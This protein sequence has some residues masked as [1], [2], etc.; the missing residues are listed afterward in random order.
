MKYIFVPC[1]LYKTNNVR[2]RHSIVFKRHF[3][4]SSLQQKENNLSYS[5]LPS[6]IKVFVNLEDNNLVLSYRKELKGKAGIYSIVNTVN[7]KQY[8]GSAKDLYLRLIEH[9]SNKKSNIALQNS[10]LKYGLNK[11]NFYIYEYF[12]YHSKVISNKALTDL[13][14]SYI[15]LYPFDNLY[16]FMRTATSLVGYKHTDEARLKM[17]K[18]FEDKFNHPMYGKKH[19]DNA[20]KLISKPGELNAMYGKTHSIA[21]KE[22][23]SNKLS[24]YP[25]G[26]GIYDLEDNLIKKFKNNIELA[27]Y[28]DISRVTVGKYLNSGLVYKEK[29]RFLVNK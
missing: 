23:I 29:Y 21:T 28:L 14:T 27:K 2:Y 25:N 4:Y 3:S 7:N 12:T 9:I 10:I 13:E 24:K 11:F 8:I 6:P 26:I 19:S 18:R 16:N 17:L 15:K 5:S 22:I 1:I 20:R